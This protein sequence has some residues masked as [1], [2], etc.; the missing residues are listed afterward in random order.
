MPEENSVNKENK[1]SGRIIKSV[2]GFCTIETPDGVFSAKPRGIFRL[3]GI[4]PVVGDFV[5]LEREEV[6]GEL[7]IS[8]IKDRNNFLVRPPLANLDM[9]IFV[10]SACEPKPNTLITDKLISISHSKGIKAVLVFTKTDLDEIGDFANIYEK[11]GYK[12]FEIDN[13]SGRGVDNVKNYING[14]FTALIGNSGVGKSSLLNAI[15]P[16]LNLNTQEI[17]T[18]LGR[19]K[20]TTRH[21][22]IFS[23]DNICIADTPGFST[24]DIERYGRIEA[25][26]LQNCFVEFKP[27][28]GQCRFA[29]CSHINESGCAIKSALESGEIGNSR[30]KS[31]TTMYNDAKKLKSWE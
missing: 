1:I 21:V 20:H 15:F 10:L 6:S 30:Y 24:V 16:E 12:V 3:R 25:V 27:F 11:I 26:D 23:D 19:G 9:I 13:L 18:K 28:I 17:S 4:S 14:K 31:Y 8:D 2:G 29:D 7:V 22:E 5:L